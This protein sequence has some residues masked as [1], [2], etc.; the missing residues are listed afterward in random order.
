MRNSNKCALF[1]F[2]GAI[3]SRARPMEGCSNVYGKRAS[4]TLFIVEVIVTVCDACG[5][6]GIRDVGYC[7]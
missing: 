1:A 6:D 4:V 5:G 3:I 7:M 2:A